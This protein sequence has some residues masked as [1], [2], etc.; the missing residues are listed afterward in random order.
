MHIGSV[1][2][3][4]QKIL[5]ILHCSQD[6]VCF[7]A[8]HFYPTKYATPLLVSFVAILDSTTTTTTLSSAKKAR[9]Y[10]RNIK[11][12]VQRFLQP[13]SKR[14]FSSPPDKL[15]YFSFIMQLRYH[16]FFEAFH[17]LW[18]QLVLFC[19]SLV[20]WLF[21]LQHSSHNIYIYFTMYVSIF[22]V[23]DEIITF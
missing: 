18:K 6:N 21:L 12:S 15:L 17:A 3:H 4:T 8:W 1:H 10:N 14:P 5:N 13:T 7:L 19:V 11:S 2:T 9:L 22:F 20:F 16:L 23:D